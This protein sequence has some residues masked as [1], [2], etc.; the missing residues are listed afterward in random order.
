MLIPFPGSFRHQ[1]SHSWRFLA[2]NQAWQS[3]NRASF[4]KNLKCR[5]FYESLFVVTQETVFI[6]GVRWHSSSVVLYKEQPISSLFSPHNSAVPARAGSGGHCLEKSLPPS[7]LW[8]ELEN[9]C[10][11]TMRF[12]R[13]IV[14]LLCHSLTLI[15]TDEFTAG[16]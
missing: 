2:D 6:G 5:F 11:H 10:F 3:P 15:F 8:S 9:E 16:L 7:T 13:C 14:M 1:F 4:N 12:S